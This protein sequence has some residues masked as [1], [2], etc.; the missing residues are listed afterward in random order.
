M[1]DHQP[2]PPVD[3]EDGDDTEDRDTAGDD[4]EPAS[5]PDVLTPAQ[6]A[7]V[8]LATE[9]AEILRG[10]T[11][12]GKN[13]VTAEE[14]TYL[15]DWL[16]GDTDEDHPLRWLDS[17]HATLFA[18][19]EA[20]LVDKVTERQRKFGPVWAE[21]M[22]KVVTQMSHAGAEAFSRE[23]PDVKVT[24]GSPSGPLDGDRA[25]ADVADRIVAW[26]N[27][28]APAP[29][30]T[31]TRECVGKDGTTIERRVADGATLGDFLDALF[32]R[33]PAT[34]DVKDPTGWEAD[35][36]RL[37]DEQDASG[38]SAYPGP[39]EGRDVD[40]TPFDLGLDESAD[41]VPDEE[42]PIEQIVVKA[43][44][45]RPGDRSDAWEILERLPDE[46][47]EIHTRSVARIQWIPDG[48]R[49]VR[50]WEHGEDIVLVER[51]PEPTDG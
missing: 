22:R 43:A 15:A 3:F 26:M 32:V 50:S 9:A 23:M 36:E 40:A 42:R 1:S 8:I 35:S 41:K 47:D 4:A 13:A 6:R 7:R 49:S 19:E 25:P 30:H 39:R 14:V 11:F 10:R 2:Y 38:A 37:A 31:H 29:D 48:G 17:D 46:E 33:P 20:P 16:E 5:E 12:V 21:A 34:G 28:F 24:W 44:D 45:L 51:G 18:A 27:A